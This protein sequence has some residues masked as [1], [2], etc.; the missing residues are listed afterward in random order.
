M[1]PLDEQ[2]RKAEID[3]NEALNAM[4]AATLKFGAILKEKVIILGKLQKLKK[5]E[6]QNTAKL[7]EILGEAKQG[8]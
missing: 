8:K 7:A 3:K 2:I 6:D 5:K 1:T 4:N